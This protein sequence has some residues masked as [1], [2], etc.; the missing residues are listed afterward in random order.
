ME[1][2]IS[3][4]L[5]KKNESQLKRIFTN[6]QLDILKKKLQKKTLNSNEKTYYYKYIKPKVKAMLLFC[7][8]AEI[9]IQGKEFLL[10]ER[11]PQAT[12]VLR[13]VEQMHRKKKIM[14]SGS[15]L[16]SKEYQDID[17][18]VFVHYKKDDYK[19]GKLHVNFINE[20][21]LDSLFFSS[22]TQVSISNFAYEA[23]K[24]FDVKLNDVLQSYE[25]LIN[26]ILN[27][28]NYEKELRDFLLTIE[29]VSKGVILNP[30]QLY[31]LKNKRINKNISGI[32]SGIFI[33]DLP[34][35]YDQSELSRVLKQRIKDYKKLS[36]EYK[37]AKNLELY[38][39]TYR[40]AIG[41]GA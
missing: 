39:D 28:E 16:F 8:I 23:K 36:K 35:S 12:K 29:Y 40:Q 24:D 7:N 25:L 2:L 22:L 17:V 1:N 26:H 3:L 19:K 10:E 20:S 6:I 38:I 11:I 27:K 15:F 31:D 18:F 9:N 33:N 41:F 32:L 21:A 4:S 34:L 13:R 14:M 37:Q 5:I 30:K